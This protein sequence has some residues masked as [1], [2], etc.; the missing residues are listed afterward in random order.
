MK[1]LKIV[2]IILCSTVALSCAAQKSKKQK[3]VTETKAKMEASASEAEQEESSAECEMNMSLFFESAKNRNYADALAPWQSVYAECPRHSKLIYTYG[4]RIINWQIENASTP[5]EKAQ[6]I[7]KLMSLY[8]DQIKYFGKDERNPAAWIKGMKAYYYALYYPE[9]KAK[10]YPLVK[11]AVVELKEASEP[12]FLQQFVVTS[13]ELYKSDAANAEQF[14]NDYLLANEYLEI[15]AN[16]PAAKNSASYR[17]LKESLDALFVVSGVADCDKLNEIYAQR[18]E[19]NKENLDF[20]NTTIRFFKRL[21][22]TDQKTFFTASKYAHMISPSSESANGMAEMNY[23]GDN[24]NKA[25]E[26]YLE[27][28]NLTDNTEEKADYF[29]KIAQIYYTKLDN[30]VK[31]KEYSKMSLANNPNQGNPYILLGVIYARARNIF[32]DPVLNKS[33][34]WAA[35]DQFIKA[36]QADQSESNVKEAN[37]L[38]G[39]YSEHFP[40]KEEL[41]MHPELNDGKSFYVGGWINENTTARSR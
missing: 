5:E 4:T 39:I 37:R 10:V 12:S 35:V 13:S 36:R 30:L 6:L 8:D 3:N 21:G 23:K 25:I 15:N 29:F 2:A 24:Y 1:N 14:I 18:V 26:Y 34:Y 28:A 20:L 16:N 32:D 38:I 27:A 9:D 33:V 19:N 31:A 7:D 40:T 41:F 17:S 11:E 22:C